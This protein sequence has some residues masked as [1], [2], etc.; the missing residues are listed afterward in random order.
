MLKLIWLIFLCLLFKGGGA[1]PEIV[2]DIVLTDDIKEEVVKSYN[3]EIVQ[4]NIHSCAATNTEHISTI[5]TDLYSRQLL[6]YG[7]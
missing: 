5:D 3:E 2:D 1:L 7:R 4:E 6:V